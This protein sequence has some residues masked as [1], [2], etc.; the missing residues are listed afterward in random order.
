MTTLRDCLQQF[1]LDKA[2][3]RAKVARRLE[4]LTMRCLSKELYSQE[5]KVILDKIA[6]LAQK[7]R[8]LS[9]ELSDD[10]LFPLAA[11]INALPAD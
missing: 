1:E 11:W 3:H 5:Q 9:F 8:G 7:M 4:V 2:T 10:D 6:S